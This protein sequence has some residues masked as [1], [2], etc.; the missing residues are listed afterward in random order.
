MRKIQTLLVDYLSKHGQIEL[1]LPDGVKLEIGIT[2]ELKG[3]LIKREDYCWVI[4]SRKGRT[5]CLDSYNLGVRFN[6]E[7]NI[8]ILEDSFL[9]HEGEQIRRLDVI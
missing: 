6:D 1:I 2:Q 3:E 5:A 7:K 9:N 8:L 4:A